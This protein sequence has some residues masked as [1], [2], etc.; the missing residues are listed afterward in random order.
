[1]KMRI[2]ILLIS[3]MLIL[4][5]SIPLQ[6]IDKART[7]LINEQEAQPRI[8]MEAKKCIDVNIES[9]NNTFMYKPE[10]YNI[11]NESQNEI[12]DYAKD[13]K[14]KVNQIDDKGIVFEK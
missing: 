4:A 9:D 5:Y 2:E 13:K 7:Y 6:V 14:L 11:L 1:M 3:L 10:K 8:I 12:F